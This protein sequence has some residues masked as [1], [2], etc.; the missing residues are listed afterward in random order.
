MGSQAT[1][2]S[3]PPTADAWP[4][5]SYEA[6]KDTYAT[7]HRW[8]QIVGKTRMGFEPM[9]NHWWQVAL[10]VSARGLTTSAMPCG[11]GRLVEMEFD[12]IDHELAIRT[13]DGARRALPL[14][15]RSVADFLAD[16]ES[17]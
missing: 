2:Q 10:Y 15:P 1:P 17:T 3:T 9:L 8:T 12:F 11:A 13:S 5:L 6:W 7:L 4:V 14:I 16:Y